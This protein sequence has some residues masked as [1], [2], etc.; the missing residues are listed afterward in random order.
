ME[1][2]IIFDDD[3]KDDYD[4]KILKWKKLNESIRKVRNGSKFKLSKIDER[5]I[6]F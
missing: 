5:K 6:V 2:L 3:L 4:R 1:N